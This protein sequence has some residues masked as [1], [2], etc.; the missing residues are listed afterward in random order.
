MMIEFLDLLASDVKSELMKRIPEGA[1]LEEDHHFWSTS[2]SFDLLHEIETTVKRI[3]GT[4]PTDRF[5]K[6][7][8]GPH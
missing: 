8:A 2:I 4:Y 3:Y 1:L 5:Q 7:K 6:E